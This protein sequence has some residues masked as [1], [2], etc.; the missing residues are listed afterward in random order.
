MWLDEVPEQRGQIETECN[1]GIVAKHINDLSKIVV[2]RYVGLVEMA[3]LPFVDIEFTRILIYSSR[4]QV[5]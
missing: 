3:E 5:P 2:Q 1:D 4:G